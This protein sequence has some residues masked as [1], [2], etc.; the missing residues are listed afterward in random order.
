MEKEKEVKRQ[1]FTFSG[2]W[3]ML[4]STE[5]KTKWRYEHEV[6][7]ADLFVALSPHM[8]AWICE[9]YIGNKRADRGVKINGQTFYFEVDLCNEG[10]SVLEE[11]IENYTKADGRFHVVFS[12]LGEPAEV[13]RRGQLLIPY[14]QKIKRGNQFLMANHT[15]LLL[16]PLAPVLY[17][18]KDELLSFTSV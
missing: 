16:D 3:F 1:A 4:P 5:K 17:S 14:L 13:T 6:A 10:T 12:F 18:P 8:E 7:A 2:D 9:P 15:K 11:K